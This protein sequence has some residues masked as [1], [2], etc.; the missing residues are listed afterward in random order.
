MALNITTHVVGALQENC[1]LVIDDAARQ[2]VLVD[3]GGEGERLVQAV[4]ASGAE[5]QAVWLTHAHVDHVLGVAAVKRAFDV[6]V[7]MHPL[8]RPLY[9]RAELSATMY[10]L[11]F[12]PLP[13]P[14]RALADGDVLTV[15]S[16]DFAVMH[17]PGHAPG[18]VVIHGHGVAFVGDC[19][20]M[21][22][23]G[24][25]DLPLSV[26]T[27]LTRSLARI[28]ELPEDTVVY[29]G[30]GPSTTVG[31]ERRTNPFLNGG[32]RVLRG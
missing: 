7:F 9:D 19:L 32:A 31:R 12:E 11:P 3:P 21:G 20:F 8:D 24:R 14:D 4:R 6:P 28:A 30:H 5:L 10:G 2:G 22:S 1:Y 17:A 26:P 13:A 29:P 16:F 27:D 15:G 18:H 23:V 25:V